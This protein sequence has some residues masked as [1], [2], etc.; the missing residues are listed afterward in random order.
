MLCYEQ[1]QVSFEAVKYPM[2][3]IWMIQTCKHAYNTKQACSSAK[4]LEHEH[5]MYKCSTVML[6][7]MPVNKLW[8]V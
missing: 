3:L 6:R 7:S 1:E 8:F 5:E 2:H 4:P